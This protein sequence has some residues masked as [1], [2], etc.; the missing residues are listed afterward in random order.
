MLY[1]RTPFTSGKSMQAKSPLIESN[2]SKYLPSFAIIKR[3][4]AEI[5]LLY[6]FVP[7]GEDYNVA[8]WEVK[9]KAFPYVTS[10]SEAFDAKKNLFPNV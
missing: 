8:R 10:E 5:E 2:R 3:N 7:G 6:L 9:R 4:E 1:F